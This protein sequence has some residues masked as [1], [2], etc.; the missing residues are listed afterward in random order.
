MTKAKKE[1]ALVQVQSEV[2]SKFLG[3]LVPSNIDVRSYTRQVAMLMKNNKTLQKCD[4]AKLLNS[5][6]QAA[7]LGLSLEQALPEAYLVPFGQ[8]CQLI[9]SYRGQM[10]LARNSGA[11]DAFDVDVVRQGDLFEVSRGTDPRIKHVPAWDNFDEEIIAAY[12]I[13]WLGEKYQFVVMSRGEVE[14]HRNMS[15]SA[16]SKTSPWN[17]WESEMF[18][19]TVLKA[20]CKLLPA[21]KEGAQGHFR[22]A[23]Y[24]DSEVDVWKQPPASKLEALEEQ[25]AEGTPNSTRNGRAKKPKTMIEEQLEEDS[26]KRLES[27]EPEL[28]GVDNPFKD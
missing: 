7:S 12:A 22:A 26:I 24:E 9:T 5:V 23:T 27:E 14:K 21:A 3:G 1:T 11:V 17:Q 2:F 16:G 4:P 19:K 20:L 15:K 6:C 25:L 13:A 10:K 28:T 8:D 18:K